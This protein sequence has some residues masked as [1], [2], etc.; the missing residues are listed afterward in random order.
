MERK[1]EIVTWMVEHGYALF[2]ESVEH[3][4]NRVPLDVLESSLVSF[5]KYKGIDL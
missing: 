5:A 3:F 4:A 1:I 2:G